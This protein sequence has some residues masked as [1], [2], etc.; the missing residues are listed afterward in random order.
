[1]QV[2]DVTD[3]TDGR[4]QEE[5]PSVRSAS[6]CPLACLRTPGRTTNHIVVLLI[7]RAQYKSQISNLKS[8]ISNRLT[9]F[10]GITSRSLSGMRLLQPS[11]GSQAYPS[12]LVADTYACH[13][14]SG[15]TEC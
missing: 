1:M 9:V 11:V 8:Q 7:D 15:C 13:R 3:V 14:I 4:K 5:V 2:T 10:C 6:W 12:S